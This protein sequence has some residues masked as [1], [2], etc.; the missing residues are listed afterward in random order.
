MSAPQTFT[1]AYRRNMRHW[2][3]IWRA[4]RGINQELACYS[5]CNAI[6]NRAWAKEAA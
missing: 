4:T 1:E 6:L 5:L 2:A 3:L